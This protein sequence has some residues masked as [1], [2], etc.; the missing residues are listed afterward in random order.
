MEILNNIWLAIST[1]N[2]E[3]VNIILLICVFMEAFMILLL[4]TSLSKIKP[5]WKQTLT[6]ILVNSCLGLLAMWLVPAPFNIFI[7]YIFP[8]VTSALIFRKSVLKLS[9]SIVVSLSLIHI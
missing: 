8:F 3:I 4:F 1:P 5:T 2:Q 7:N 9:I 6:Y